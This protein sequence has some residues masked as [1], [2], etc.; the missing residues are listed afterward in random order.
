MHA[1]T[2][3]EVIILIKCNNWFGLNLSVKISSLYNEVKCSGGL[4]RKTASCRCLGTIYLSVSRL[5]NLLLSMTFFLMSTMFSPIVRL[6]DMN[7]WIMYLYYDK[8]KCDKSKY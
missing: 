2:S 1:S 4:K 3:I 6:K 5:N 8:R 7:I